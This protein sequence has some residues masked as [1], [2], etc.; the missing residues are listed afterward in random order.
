LKVFSLLA[1]ASFAAAAA[2]AAAAPRLQ[3]PTPQQGWKRALRSFHVQ[4]A[5]RLGYGCDSLPCSG[6]GSGSCSRIEHAH[7]L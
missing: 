4:Q 1:A 2:G 7:F 6:S 5:E 3:Q